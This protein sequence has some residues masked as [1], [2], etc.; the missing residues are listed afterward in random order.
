MSTSAAPSQAEPIVIENRNGILVARPGKEIDLSS[1]KQILTDMK[2]RIDD[3]STRIIFDLAGLEFIDS[4][5]LSVMVDL[6]DAATKLGG[7]VVFASPGARVMRILRVTRL[8]RYIDRFDS[9]AEAEAA[10]N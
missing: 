7:K 9:L 8:D 2:R 5:G 3:G 6:Q 1:S 4:T 10:F